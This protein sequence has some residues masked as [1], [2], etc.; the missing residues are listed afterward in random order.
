[1]PL[2]ERPYCP[3]QQSFARL[4]AER[5]VVPDVAPARPAKNSCCTWWS[6]GWAWPSF[7]HRTRTMR[8]TVVRPLEAGPIAFER[9]LGL[10]C[11]AHDGP[12][13]AM[14]EPLAAGMRARLPQA[15]AA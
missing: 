10:A 3:Q 9:H 8:R 15:L 2:I 7:R 4:L 1:M 11:A 13:S 12:T 6:W 5:G 14:L